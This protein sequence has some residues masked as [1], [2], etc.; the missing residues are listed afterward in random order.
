MIPY[1]LM[2]ESPPLLYLYSVS[3]RRM[4]LL[5]QLGIHYESFPIDSDESIP[6]GRSSQEVVVIIAMRKLEAGILAVPAHSEAWGLAADTLVEGPSGLLGKPRDV[7]DAAAMLHSLSGI[8]HDV[9][10]GIAVY[11][12]RQTSV[13]EAQS[14]VHTTKVTFKNLTD[15]DVSSYIRTCEWEDVAGAYRIQGRGASLVEKIDG[16][17]STVVGLPLSPLYGILTAMSY[18]FG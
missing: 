17:W 12:P 15:S 2:E 16:L 10:T 4:D 9:H 5:N 3:P 13:E 1:Y 6:E 18:P 8:T 11:S 7:L 14:L